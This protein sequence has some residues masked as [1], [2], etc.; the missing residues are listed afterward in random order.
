MELFNMYTCLEECL[1]HSECAIKLDYVSYHFIAFYF[2]IY[3]LPSILALSPFLFTILILF[4]SR[5]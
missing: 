5:S 4:L 2:I 3:D 1:A